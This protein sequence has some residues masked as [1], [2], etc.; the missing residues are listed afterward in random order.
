MAIEI[1]NVDG[2]AAPKDG[3]IFA[4]QYKD[5]VTK[6]RWSAARNDWEGA[7]TTDGRW[8]ALEYLRGRSHPQTWWSIQATFDV[9]SATASNLVHLQKV[10]GVDNPAAVIRKAVA[11]ANV[12][13]QHADTDKTITIADGEGK[14]PVK[15]SLAE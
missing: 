1:K 14:D 2:E 12:A 3:T 6:V 8:I 11:L 4:A 10:F 13:A 9:D 7:T 5:G 15:V